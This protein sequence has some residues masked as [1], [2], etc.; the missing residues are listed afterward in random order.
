MSNQLYDY[1][2]KTL[3]LVSKERIDTSRNDLL[4]DRIHLKRVSALSARTSTHNRESNSNQNSLRQDGARWFEYYKDI[5]PQVPI[6]ELSPNDHL[7]DSGTKVLH[8][9]CHD[10]DVASP[11][12][13]HAAKKATHITQRMLTISHEMSV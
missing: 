5:G 3:Q 11:P 2:T 13:S 6:Y 10:S 4:D 8:G 12:H 7:A 1:P 9:R